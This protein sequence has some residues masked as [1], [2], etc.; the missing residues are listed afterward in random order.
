MPSVTTIL[1]IT[2]C[3][4]FGNAAEPTME[5]DPFFIHPYDDVSNYSLNEVCAHERQ[6]DRDIFGATFDR[7]GNRRIIIQIHPHLR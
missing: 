5:D 4:P 3:I 6:K 1:R 2:T 7:D